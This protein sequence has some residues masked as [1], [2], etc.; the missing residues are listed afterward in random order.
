MMMEGGGTV[1]EVK[2]E[3]QQDLAASSTL[4]KELR[5]VSVCVVHYYS[6]DI[7]NMRTHMLTRTR[8]DRPVNIN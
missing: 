7:L 6:A 4:L 8:T 5:T 2:E 1:E 3:S